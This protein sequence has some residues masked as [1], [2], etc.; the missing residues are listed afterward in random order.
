MVVAIAVL[1]VVVADAGMEIAVAVVGIGASLVEVVE[2][3]SSVDLEELML[4][5]GEEMDNLVGVVIAEGSMVVH[6]VL[7]GFLRCFCGSFDLCYSS[8]PFYYGFFGIFSSGEI[9]G[10]LRFFVVT[11][12][13][14]RGTIL[15]TFSRALTLFECTL[16]FLHQSLGFPAF[17]SFFFVAFLVQVL[18]LRNSCLGAFLFSLCLSIFYGGCPVLYCH[19]CYCF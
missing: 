5:L 18:V 11:W 4:L 14:T 8:Y 3:A 2:M 10:F 1:L 12:I 9:C 17:Y 19:L 15:E 16:H 6:V 7:G 13:L